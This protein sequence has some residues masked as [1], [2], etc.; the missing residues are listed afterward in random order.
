ME[1]P[2]LKVSRYDYRWQTGDETSIQ[3]PKGTILRVEARFNN[4]ASNKLKP[5]PNRTVY[6]GQETWEEMQGGYYD[7]V[8]P[9]NT[10]PRNVVTRIRNGAPSPA[11]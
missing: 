10:N 9:M 1:L 4:S 11:P 5:N 3:V 2:V 8:I 7:F 6:G